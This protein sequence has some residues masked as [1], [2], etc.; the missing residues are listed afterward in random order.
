M[1][2][3]SVTYHIVVTLLM[4]SSLIAGGLG[5]KHVRQIG[6]SREWFRKFAK[7]YLH[8][9]HPFVYD[10]FEKKVL[11]YLNHFFVY[12]PQIINGLLDDFAFCG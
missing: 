4:V 7:N 11:Y 8:E 5:K 1:K 12:L 9:P 6:G 2:R 10:E 3:R